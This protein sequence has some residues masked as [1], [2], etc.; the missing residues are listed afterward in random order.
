MEVSLT[1]H[2]L[3]EEGA[4]LS[5]TLLPYLNMVMDYSF[6]GQESVFICTHFLI[7]LIRHVCDMR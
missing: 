3:Q 1:N 5:R 6:L 2:Q 4:T 7:A